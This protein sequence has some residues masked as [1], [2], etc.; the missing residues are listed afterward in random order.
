MQ[1]EEEEV[2]FKKP[3][4]SQNLKTEV[5]KRSEKV[6][7]VDIQELRNDQTRIANFSSTAKQRQTE[8]LCNFKLN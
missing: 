3:A 6:G 8:S 1:N 2:D 7:S 5:R 4:Q